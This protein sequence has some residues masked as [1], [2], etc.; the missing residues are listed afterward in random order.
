MCR[1]PSEAAA[2][3]REALEVGAIFRAFGTEYRARHRLSGV[4]DKAMRAIE[5][6]RTAELGGHLDQCPRCGA[7]RPVYN[8]CRNRHC[9]KCQTLAKERWL[10]ARRAEVLPVEYFHL[11]FTLPHEIHA[12][13]IGRP[14][15][16]Y[17]VLFEAVSQT[18]LAFARDEERGL[19]GEPGITAILH[20][21][22]QN[23]TL[24]IHLHCLVT[25]GALSKDGA[26]WRAAQPGF[27]FPVKALS[28][29][30]RA[31]YL[32]GLERAHERGDLAGV[33]RGELARLVRK[34]R[35]HEWVVYA[36]R[37][38]AGAEQVLGYLGRYTHRVALT[39]DR[40]VEL[41]GDRVCFTWK[42][43]ADAS[44][45]KVM[46]LPAE[47]FIQRFLLH[48]LPERFVRIRHY[49]IL[50]NRAKKAKLSRCRRLLRA[51]P[52]AQPC[53]ETLEQIMERLTGIDIRLCPACGQARMRR[54]PLPS[55][56]LRGPLPRPPPT[57]P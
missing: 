27:L 43:Y 28:K 19:G 41:G 32:E 17:S 9:P 47:T 33:G 14:R 4:Q 23:L 38:M 11:V 37:P 51:D 39:N 13:A 6:C 42:D 55:P 50:A 15:L 12:L 2:P 8:S 30:Y 54:H 52:P 29:V 53:D 34:L 40:L 1:P 35:R 45:R 44:R 20:T 36:K 22:G 26:R 18:L 5:R 49:G 10:G 3:H 7:S 57:P 25:G 24:H 31:K 56:D 21:W 16:V 48:V 46:S